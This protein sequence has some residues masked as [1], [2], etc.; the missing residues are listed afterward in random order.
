MAYMIEK[1]LTRFA[2]QVL[3]NTISCF[4]LFHATGTISWHFYIESIQYHIYVLWHNLIGAS[5]Y[6]YR[7]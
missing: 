6:A 5:L 1:S 7:Y 3:W 4:N 2:H